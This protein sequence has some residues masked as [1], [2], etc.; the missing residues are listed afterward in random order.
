MYEYLR[1]YSTK[2]QNASEDDAWR[3]NKQ[4]SIIIGCNLS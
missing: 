2:V 3:Y 1:R 4:L